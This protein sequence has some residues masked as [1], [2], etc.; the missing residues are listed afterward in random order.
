MAS[1][2]ALIQAAIEGPNGHPDGGPD[3]SPDGSPDVGPD[4]GPDEKPNRGPHSDRDGGRIRNQNRADM[5]AMWK[6]RW[7][8]RLRARL[9]FDGALFSLFLKAST[10]GVEQGPS[11]M[12]AQFTE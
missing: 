7:S 2:W 5:V 4:A 10:G 11:C 8:R 3:R 12:L 9:G 6:L 1:A